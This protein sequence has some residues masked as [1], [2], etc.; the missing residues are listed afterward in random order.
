MLELLRIEGGALLDGGKQRFDLCKL[1]SGHVHGKILSN[2]ASPQAPM[3][4]TT[5]ST[6]ARFMSL[7]RGFTQA[8]T[9]LFS[10]SAVKPK[11]PLAQAIVK[12][13]GVGT[14]MRDDGSFVSFS[15]SYLV[16]VGSDFND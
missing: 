11:T 13:L 7:N 10:S 2:G 3:R 16:I 8:A 9:A 14:A 12:R 1:V 6:A 15:S 5:R 4:E